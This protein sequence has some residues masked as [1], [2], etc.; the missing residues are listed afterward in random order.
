MASDSRIGKQARDNA[1]VGATAFHQEIVA[2][3]VSQVV[4]EMFT[5]QAAKTMWSRRYSASDTNDI[6]ATRLSTFPV[7]VLAID[8]T[9]L[10]L[11]QVYAE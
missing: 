1:T 11:T 10:V 9:Y 4:C 2:S 3:P 8:R 5:P 7:D 6:S